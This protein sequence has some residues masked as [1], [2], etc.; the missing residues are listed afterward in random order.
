MMESFTLYV[1]LNKQLCY[2]ERIGKNTHPKLLF[3]KDMNT[4]FTNL[5]KTAF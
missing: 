2:Y 4:T 3:S 1:L 5:L